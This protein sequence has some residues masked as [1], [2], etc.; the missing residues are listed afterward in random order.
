[1]LLAVEGVDV[2]VE[3]AAIKVALD[4]AEDLEGLAEGLDVF[5]GWDWSSED[6]GHEAKQDHG[7]GDEKDGWTE[8]HLVHVCVVFLDWRVE[9]GRK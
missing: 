8:E 4:C 5:D 9:S 2:L 7:D 1:M 3:L 6:S